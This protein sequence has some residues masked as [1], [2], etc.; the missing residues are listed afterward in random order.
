MARERQYGRYLSAGELQ[1]IKR[2]TVRH[3]DETSK[4]DAETF[5]TTTSILSLGIIKLK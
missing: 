3:Y 5:A 1:T 2:K 4:L